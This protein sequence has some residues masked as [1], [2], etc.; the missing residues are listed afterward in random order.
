MENDH[1]SWH[2]HVSVDWLR[3]DVHHR[4]NTLLAT[5]AAGEEYTQGQ[6]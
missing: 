5:A 1:V 4:D 3:A 2:K 6:K